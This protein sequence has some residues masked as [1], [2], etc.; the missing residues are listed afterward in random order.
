MPATGKNDRGKV[1]SKFNFQE[2]KQARG[3]SI[4]TTVSV[5]FAV[6]KLAFK[7]GGLRDILESYFENLQVE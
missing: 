4:F 6:K 3:S 1:V 2:T 5:L 7:M